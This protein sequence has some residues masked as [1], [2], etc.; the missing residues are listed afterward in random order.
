MNDALARILPLQVRRT[1]AVMDSRPL[2]GDQAGVGAR[3]MD[4]IGQCADHSMPAAS[5]D[6]GQYDH[7][8]Q[9]RIGLGTACS[10]NRLRFAEMHAKVGRGACRRCVLRIT[11]KVCVPLFVAH[12]C[13]D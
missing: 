3:A 7:R 2:F 12:R 1:L 4:C 11:G 8:H 10:R 9:C 6:L 5:R 13:D